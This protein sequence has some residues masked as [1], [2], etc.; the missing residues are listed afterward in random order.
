MGF[1][2][3]VFILLI[4]AGLAT[5]L[6]SNYDQTVVICFT[7]RICTKELSLAAALVSAMVSGFLLAVG[8]SFPNQFR[9]RQ[10]LR[11]LQRNNDQL[12]LEVSEL[13][14]MSLSGT[15]DQSLNEQDFS[16]DQNSRFP[17]T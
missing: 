11:E 6:W 15:S 13:Q 3:S 10:R 1:L 8:L 17:T 7:E 16:E 12:E 9:L 5:F 14:Q 2:R 4:G